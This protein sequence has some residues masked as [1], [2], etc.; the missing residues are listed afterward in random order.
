MHQSITNCMNLS[1]GRGHIK[2][3]FKCNDILSNIKFWNKQ[4]A[5][6]V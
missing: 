6:T 2:Q 4:P 5:I 3:F 1:G